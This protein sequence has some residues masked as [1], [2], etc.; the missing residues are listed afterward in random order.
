MHS[1]G[2]SVAYLGLESP[3]PANDFIRFSLMGKTDSV[4]ATVDN[5]IG[6]DLRRMNGKFRSILASC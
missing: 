4:A 3:M 1:L 5:V 2:G 6:A